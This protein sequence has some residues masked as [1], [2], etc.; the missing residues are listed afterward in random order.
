VLAQMALARTLRDPR[1]TSTLIGAS[2]IKQLEENVAALNDLELADDELE[3]ID[4]HAVEAGINL[5][6][7]SSA[8]TGS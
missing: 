3:A 2:S 1:V 8:V 5:W 6:A 4:R 7:P